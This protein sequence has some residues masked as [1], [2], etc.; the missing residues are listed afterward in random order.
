[1]R[2][3]CQ[4]NGSGYLHQGNH[5]ETTQALPLSPPVW[6]ATQAFANGTADISGYEICGMEWEDSFRSD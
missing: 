6:T 5:T 2:I 1:M 3:R 4:A